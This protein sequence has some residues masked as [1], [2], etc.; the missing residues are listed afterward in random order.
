MK[1]IKQLMFALI[2]GQTLLLATGCSVLGFGIGAIKDSKK[3]EKIRKFGIPDEQ[4]A[5]KPVQENDHIQI[6]LKNGER[7]DGGFVKFVRQ[8]IG[9][10][11]QESLV[12]H[13]MQTDQQVLTKATE[14]ERIINIKNGQDKWTDIKEAANIKGNS[15]IKIFLKDGQQLEGRFLKHMEH[16]VG[17]E[18]V[19][20]IEWYDKANNRH[21]STQIADIKGII[22]IEN[23]KDE[24]VGLEEAA[25]IKANSLI[26]MVMKDGQQME[27]RFLRQMEQQVANVSVI[28]IEWYDEKNQRVSTQVADIEGIVVKQKRNRKWRGLGTGAA[29]DAMFA[30]AILKNGLN[31]DLSD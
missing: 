30:V 22:A 23:E 16:Q 8:K 18:Y 31:I 24:W 12:W 17:N 20:T 1:Q 7:L 2:I 9:D 13:D 5:A 27:G 21:E 28:T 26:E 6:F 29:I 14:I 11:I 10:E 15:K 19:A 3:N 4:A 25:T